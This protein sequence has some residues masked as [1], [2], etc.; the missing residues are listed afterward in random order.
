MHR[1]H[2][3]SG[4]SW[5]SLGAWAG[6]ARACCRTQ[7]RASSLRQQM[8]RIHMLSALSTPSHCA[9]ARPPSRLHMGGCAA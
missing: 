1:W 4:T 6:G 9:S 2:G 3:S 8:M 7:A 5:Q